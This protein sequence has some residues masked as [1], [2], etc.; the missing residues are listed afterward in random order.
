MIA[1]ASLL[2]LGFVVGEPNSFL[3]R[4]LHIAPGTQR[5]TFS[6]IALMIFDQAD[7]VPGIWVAL[8]PIW[9]MSCLQALVAFGVAVFAHLM[10]NVIGYAIGARKTWL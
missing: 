5:H 10:V 7:F 8:P 9:V 3:K 2:G 6:G 1:Y 4:Q